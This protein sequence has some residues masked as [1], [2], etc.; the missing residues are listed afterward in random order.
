MVY[1]FISLNARHKLT[2]KD[3]NVN[4]Q[5]LQLQMFFFKFQTVMNV[6]NVKKTSITYY[7]INI[8]GVNISKS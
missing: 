4:M 7:K 3:I 5:V 6:I 8:F 2:C 1:K